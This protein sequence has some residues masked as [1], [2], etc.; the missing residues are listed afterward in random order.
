MGKIGKIVK[1]IA[2]V[3]KSAAAGA[4][5]KVTL[6]S[7]MTDTDK[8]YL[9][10]G[11]E[12]GYTS[13]HVYY[14]V[15]G[16]LTDGGA[17]GG[18]N[19]DNTLSVS[20]QAADAK[21]TGD[22]I[23]GIK[24]DLSVLDTRVETVEIV[25]VTPAIGGMSTAGLVVGAATG[26]YCH[27]DKIQVQE[28]DTFRLVAIRNGGSANI[29]YVTAFNGDTVIQASGAENVLNYTVPSGI[30]HIVISGT[31]ATSKDAGTIPYVFRFRRN[32]APGK[33]NTGA[34]STSGDSI[35]DGDIVTLPAEN[36]LKNTIILF[37]TKISTFNSIALGRTT[38]TDRA[39][40]VDNTNIIVTNDSGT[41]I[42]TTPH[43]LTI[44]S[45]ITVR[46][47]IG[48]AEIKVTVSS[49]GATSE[50]VTSAWEVAATGKVR[51]VSN[52]ST[53]TDYTL[54]FIP[55]D[56]N[57]KA[58]IFGD[59]YCSIANNRWV[60][61]LRNSGYID[62]VL[63]NAYPGEGTANGIPSLLNL[64]GGCGARYILWAYGMNDGDGANSISTQWFSGVNVFITACTSRGII[65]ILATIPTV[66]TVNNEHKNAWVRSSGYRYIDFA[67]AVGAQADGTWTQGML[68]TDGV[69]P[70]TA[71]AIA[72]FNRALIDLPE[73]MQS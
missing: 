51:V 25:E 17:Y 56:G 73:L 31:C 38:H 5:T 10:I 3:R 15:D 65:P 24:E 69:H 22:E 2:D 44:A 21:K 68:S 39:V 70:T 13:G 60:G 48:I 20:G 49:S 57:K 61:Q 12:A 63:V 55:T 46:V 8:N 72:L 32:T 62:N 34:I 6:V 14:Y 45:D 18:V 43:G 1:D 50:I 7:Q 52:G 67:D 47:E 23:A 30:T 54:V 53:F 36:V 71:G 16:N 28:G 27:T 41:A 19:I 9:Y 66:P 26:T 11:S 29:K 35:S 37:S 58:W 33:G 4:P 42:S 64:V 40:I 59:S